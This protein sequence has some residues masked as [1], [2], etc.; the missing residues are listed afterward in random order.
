MQQKKPLETPKSNSQASAIDNKP[1]SKDEVIKKAQKAA[2]VLEKATLYGI[3]ADSDFKKHSADIDWDAV[4]DEAIFKQIEKAFRGNKKPEDLVREVF[5]AVIMIPFMIVYEY[6]KR[7]NKALKE[8]R[9]KNLEEKEKAIKES[10]KENKHSK[11]SLTVL[12]ARD[13]QKFLNDYS[14]LPF[15]SNGKIEK[16]QLTPYQK[17]HYKKYLFVSRLPRTA[18][19]S[20][21]FHR[22][23]NAQ[24]KQFTQWVMMYATKNP[25]FRK[26]INR[27]AAAY[28]P[29][30]KFKELGSAAACMC[31]ESRGPVYRSQHQHTR[32]S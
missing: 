32:C 30:A 3:R 22:F 28:V 1:V 23:T 13:V 17:A 21:D 12:I 11:L 2:D 5:F 6:L 14:M 18:E 31:L 24:K 25:T 9:K 20:F 15:D 16:N 26:Y 10:L 4:L 29:K 27:M 8:A 19:G 7:K